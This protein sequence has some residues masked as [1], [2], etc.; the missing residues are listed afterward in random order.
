MILQVPRGTCNS[1][2]QKM[3]YNIGRD[4]KEARQKQKQKEEKK[5]RERERVRV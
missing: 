2:T 4:W 5:E 1:S 3:F